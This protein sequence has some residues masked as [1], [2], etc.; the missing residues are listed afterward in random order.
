MKKIISLIL[1]C[2]LC[3]VSC[4]KKDTDTNYKTN[5][6]VD[7]IASKIYDII[8]IKDLTEADQSWIALNIPIDLSLSTDS[9][10]FINTTGKS[11][12]FGVFKADTE[13]NAKKLL[14][15]SEEYLETLEANWM[16]EYLAEELPKIENAIAKKCGLYV[17]FLIVDDNVRDLS[18]AEFENML[19]E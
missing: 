5:V 2:V 16:S 6:A 3:L 19:K 14:E 8:G 10:I 13:E 1:I 15:Q 9:A 4:G 17:V 12:I 7:N 11:D 18:A